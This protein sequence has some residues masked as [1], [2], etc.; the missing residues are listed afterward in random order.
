M[1]IKRVLGKILLDLYV[2]YFYSGSASLACLMIFSLC[3]RGVFHINLG[4]ICDC[5]FRLIF[6]FYVTTLEYLFIYK[7]FLSHRLILE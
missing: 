4:I 2:N 3:V 6:L 1:I 7:I 5:D